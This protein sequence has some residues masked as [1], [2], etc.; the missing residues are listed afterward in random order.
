MTTCVID[1]E[2]NFA[3]SVVDTGGAT[4]AA[5]HFANILKILNHNNGK[6]AHDT[7]PLNKTNLCKGNHVNL[8]WQ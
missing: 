3:A 8:E 1:T 7:C 5:N 4:L 6:I 2:S